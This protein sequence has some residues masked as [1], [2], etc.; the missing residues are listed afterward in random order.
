[1][2]LLS[3]FLLLWFPSPESAQVKGTIHDAQTGEALARVTV[4]L[5]ESGT[6]VETDGDGNFKIEGVAPGHYHLVISSVGYRL[7]DKQIDLKADDAYSL[8]LVLTPE[9]SPRKDTVEV[10]A[11]SFDLEQGQGPTAFTIS[12]TEAK[13]FTRCRRK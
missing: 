12:G 4:K 7:V 9:A 5:V 6:K 3:L 13:N 2:S 11:N 10:H 1:M 8:D